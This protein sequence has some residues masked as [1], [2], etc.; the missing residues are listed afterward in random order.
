[1][2]KKAIDTWESYIKRSTQK[3]DDIHE[4]LKSKH[5]KRK[6]INAHIYYIEVHIDLAKRSKEFMEL[7]QNKYAS[8]KSDSSYREICNEVG[9]IVLNAYATAQSVSSKEESSSEERINIAI[10]SSA[11]LL[12]S[13]KSKMHQVYRNS[14]KL[15]FS[16]PLELNRQIKTIHQSNNINP[17]KMISESDIQKAS[18]VITLEL[19][20]QVKRDCLK[21]FKQAS[22]D[23]TNYIK[24]YYRRKEILSTVGPIIAATFIDLFIGS[25]VL[26]PAFSPGTVVV[27][28]LFLED[29]RNIM[30]EESI[31]KA[32]EL[33]WQNNIIF[34]VPMVAVHIGLMRILSE[35]RL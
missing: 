25:P 3:K 30:K 27:D 33:W 2:L 19:I 32:Q 24:R 10:E 22:N 34:I 17:K 7:F 23:G 21:F 12:E 26:T 11:Q 8:I 29:K 15:L 16:D 31:R 4:K 9:K 18:V 28:K 5:F 14:C 13:L 6:H 20:D 35:I 1:M